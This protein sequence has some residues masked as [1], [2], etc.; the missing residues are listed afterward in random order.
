MQRALYFTLLIA[1]V[2][3]PVAGIQPLIITAGESESVSLEDHAQLQFREAG[4]DTERVL[5]RFDVREDGAAAVTVEYRFPVD[6]ATGGTAFA[7]L[8]RDIAANQTVYLYR[9]ERRVTEAVQTAATSTDRPMNVT[10]VAVRAEIRQLPA[11]YGV[12]AYSFTWHGFAVLEDGDLR[13]GDALAGLYLEEGTH[14]QI[15]WPEGYDARSVHPSPSEQRDRAAIWAGSVWFDQAGPEVELARGGPGIDPVPVALLGVSVLLAASGLAFWW[16]ASGGPGPTATGPS[17]GTDPRAT[18]PD[19]GQENP[20]DPVETD[21]DVELLSN[22]E[23]VLWEIE[24]RG[25]R[26]KQRELV[27]ALEWSDA[28]VSRAVTGLR[29][30]G[31][32]EGFRIGNENVLSLPVHEEPKGAEE[33]S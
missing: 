32:L 23:R 31:A 26:V 3:A 11:P 21:V 18:N 12:V 6:D 8:Q 28:K 2:A 1:L 14:L 9:F 16:R 29:E 19:G 15:S 17:E 13:V 4:L 25:G 20:P 33:E 27:A 30:D 22:E 10:D 5:L 7:G 24:R